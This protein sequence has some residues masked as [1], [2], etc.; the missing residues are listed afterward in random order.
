MD[1][2]AQA[3]QLDSED[4]L[5]EKRKAFSIPDNTI[6]LDGNSL[7]PASHAAQMAGQ[8]VLDAQWQTDLITSWNVHDWIRLPRIVGAL[9]APIIG[10]QA[11]S[12]IACDST[13]INLYKL[14]H[15]ALNL[16]PDRHVIMTQ[17]GNFPSDGYIAQ[18][19]MAHRSEVSLIYV[20][21]Q[22]IIAQLD[23]SIA[24]LMLT[25]VN[26]KTGYM[27]D[28]AKITQ[29]AHALGILVI[30][31]LAHSAGALELS[32]D[33]HEVDFAVG[34]GY[35]Y[36]NGG[37]GAPA[38]VYVNPI[39]LNRLKQPLAGWMGHANAFAFEQ[40]YVPSD[41]I[42]SLL[43]GTPNIVSMA[44]LK[45]ALTVFSDV[46]MSDV[47][48][49]SLK[50]SSFMVSVIEQHP[51]L[52]SLELVTDMDDARRGSQIAL[53]HPDAYAICQAWIEQG[54]MADFR[55]PNILRI[56]FAPLYISYF[57]VLKATDSLAHIMQ[58]KTYRAQQYQT[59]NTVT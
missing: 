35:K 42:D 28:M 46:H 18:G 23:E 32:L 19:L 44:V 27:L 5:K 6:Y 47:R 2:L 49:K 38:F 36:L 33:E 37:P 26:Y 7:G 20:D 41:G 31:D 11:D 55:E 29:A 21:E 58:C 15:S 59:R 25:H 17:Q 43:C 24:V 39:H 57:D 22:D 34:C 9:I 13:S 54:V 3:Q 16:Q 50:L 30:W 56:G 40:D 1:I 12:V 53:A 8:S 52:Q 4:V 51:A 10:A 45:G 48:Q 14:L